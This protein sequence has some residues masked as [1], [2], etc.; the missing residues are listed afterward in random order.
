MVVHGLVLGTK[1]TNTLIEV[2][3]VR[4]LTSE[5]VH[6]LLAV[7]VYALIIESAIDGILEGGVGCGSAARDY[8]LVLC[9]PFAA[10]LYCVY[11]REKVRETERVVIVQKEN[12]SAKNLCLKVFDKNSFYCPAVLSPTVPSR[13]ATVDRAL[14]ARLLFSSAIEFLSSLLEFRE[15]RRTFKAIIE[16][17]SH[18]I[19]LR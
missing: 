9:E 15:A 10:M 7:A 13:D 4:S 11:I 8:V 5:H 2:D 19:S 6:R 1:L 16:N 12:E 14:L 18:N 17:I 3:G